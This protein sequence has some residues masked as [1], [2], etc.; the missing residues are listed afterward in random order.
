MREQKPPTPRSTRTLIVLGWIL[1]ILVIVAV[2]WAWT[3]WNAIDLYV[4]S[5]GRVGGL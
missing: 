1:A 5:E 4:K 2:G 3:E